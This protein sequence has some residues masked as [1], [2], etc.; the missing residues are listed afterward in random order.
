MSAINC[1]NQVRFATKYDWKFVT[2]LG[3]YIPLGG[4]S[5]L[6]K[7]CSEVRVLLHF[8]S[9]MPSVEIPKHWC[10]A[11]DKVAKGQRL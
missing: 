8:L 4:L 7:K 6:T 2:V 11:L 3:G 9:A 5:K 10:N 1:S